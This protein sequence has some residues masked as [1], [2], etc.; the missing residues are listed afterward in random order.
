M[1]TPMK[2]VVEQAMVDISGYPAELVDGQFG[3]VSD[4]LTAQLID[5]VANGPG[6]AA[7]VAAR[8]S[9]KITS[10]PVNSEPSWNLTPLRSLNSQVVGSMARHDVARPGMMRAFSSTR[11]NASNTCQPMATLCW[12]AT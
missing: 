8:S 2:D 9:E 11:V 1:S 7:S 5:L 3:P 4:D 12:V 6:L 10:S